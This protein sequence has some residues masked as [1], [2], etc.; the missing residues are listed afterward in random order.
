MKNIQKS[1]KMK[2][3][4]K[5]I[6]SAVMVFS[7]LLL[8]SSCDEPFLDEDLR[9]ALSPAVFFNNLNEAEMAVNGVYALLNSQNLYR[10]RNYRGATQ[11]G[12]D[13]VCP[14]RKVVQTPYNYLYTEGLGDLFAA[15]KEFYLIIRNA[16]SAIAY[17]SSADALS[18]EEK[19]QLLGELYVLRALAYYDLTR[20]WGDVPFF[21]EDLGTDEL[22]VLPRTP[23][24]TIRSQMKTDLALAKSL[25]PSAYSAAGDK[26]RM[27]KW[28]ASALKAKFHLFDKE[29]SETLA[30]CVDIINNSPH[31]LMDDFADVYGY[32]KTTLDNEIKEEHILWVDFA[33][34]TALGTNIINTNGN[35][36][37]GNLQT[38][39]WI[40]EF[41]PRLK[42]NPKA[43][44][45]KNALN[46]ALAANDQSM[47]GF[48]A[49]IACPDISKRG[50]WDAGDLRYDVTI[51]EYYE[52]IQL[53]FPYV[54]KLMN[55]NIDKPRNSKSENIVLIRLADIYL[56]AAESENE[57]N[58][59]NNAYQYVNKVR[60]RAFEPDMPW[61]GMTQTNFRLAMM[62]ERKFE[63]FAEG[64][65]KQDLIRWGN[66]IETVQNTK[67][68]RHA[69]GAAGNIQTK[70]VKYPIPLN[71]VQT[72][73]GLLDSDPT[74][75]GYR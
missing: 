26:G 66:L 38:N 8:P 46:A 70:H 71:E 53:K 29:W 60:E 30:E 74:N 14:Q 39:L 61:T 58:G 16:N 13:E 32:D 47:T 57:L 23:M 51:M 27:T 63:L 41:N 35:L 21:T 55:L 19:N 6:L 34:A 3:T 43:K 25:L 45:D 48:G 37:S 20:F 54:G 12:T 62:D 17:I 10:N 72:N 64:H 18:T 68:T 65:R 42:D 31:K 67:V 36:N 49:G 5:N 52:G 11:F 15:W 56:M 4:Y 7:L 59:P 22:A 1:N 75:N 40:E 28:A 2:N 24:S 44:G 9:D 50:N 69:Q 73:P 33:G